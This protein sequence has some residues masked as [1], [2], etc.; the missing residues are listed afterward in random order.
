MSPE[1]H[2]PSDEERKQRAVDLAIERTELAAERTE[3]AQERTKL[4]ARR[5]LM[6]LDRT[7]MAWIRTAVTLIGVGIALYELLSSLRPTGTPSGLASAEAVALF[8]IS[9]GVFALAAA[10]VHYWYV[11]GKLGRDLYPAWK[12]TLSVACVV[13]VI[14]V[15]LVIALAF[16]LGPLF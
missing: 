3:L 9:L 6:A 16:G 7:F 4:A 2:Q 12:L 11:T 8:L 13:M 1:Q 10:T 5:T 14:G 15:L